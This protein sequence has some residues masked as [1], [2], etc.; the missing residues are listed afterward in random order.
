[1]AEDRASYQS[2]RR[3]LDD[4]LRKK[5]SAAL[6][7]FLVAEGQCQ[8]DAA[9]DVDAAMWMMIATS[10]ALPALHG[11]A[12]QW[13]LNH[14]HQAEAN[15]IFGGRSRASQRPASAGK[16]HTPN[17][18]PARNRPSA[19]PGAKHPPARRDPSRPHRPGQPDRTGRRD[20]H[21]PREP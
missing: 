14:G 2:F 3:R 7:A 11:E 12:E 17:K 21:P 1:M 20:G 8:A 15:A 5:D 10:P 19:P 16:P 9:T 13:L 6:R 18:A 4:V